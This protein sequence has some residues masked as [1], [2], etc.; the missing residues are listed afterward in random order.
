[1]LERL[2]ALRRKLLDPKIVEH[3]VRIVKTTGSLDRLAQPALLPGRGGVVAVRRRGTRFHRALADLVTSAFAVLLVGGFGLAF[4]A[5]ITLAMSG[6]N[7]WTLNIERKGLPE[8]KALYRL[9]GVE[10]NVTAKCWPE[11]G[12]NYNQVSRKMMYGWF[13]K[14]LKLG[15]PAELDAAIKPHAG[16]ARH[17]PFAQRHHLVVRLV[18]SC[19]SFEKIDR[20]NIFL[21]GDRVC[22]I[23]VDLVVVRRGGGFGSSIVTGGSVDCCDRSACSACAGG[24][25]VAA[26]RHAIVTVQDGS[27]AV[28]GP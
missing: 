15:Q 1:M 18:G 3:R 25:A 14:H 20:I 8:L 4:P 23:V 19:P 13:T 12:H 22:V 16:P 27:F 9:Y 5:M 10:D 21:L 17:R 6:A 2:K 7:D 11:F 28:S 26:S 24:I